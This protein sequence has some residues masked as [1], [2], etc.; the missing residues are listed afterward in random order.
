MR[1]T[2][3][4]VTAA[5]VAAL[6]LTACSGESGD[7]TAKSSTDS[8]SS[9]DSANGKSTAC[10]ADQ[11]GID[12]GPS[13]AAPAAGD[14]GTIPV[15]LTNQGASCTLDGIPDADVY[16][17]DT[18]WAVSPDKAATA[19]KL[20]MAKDQAVTF[21]ITYVRGVAGDAKKAAAVDTVKFTLPGDSAPQS[22]KWPD[23]EVAVKSGDQ[24]DMTVGP[25][26]PAGD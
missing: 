7:D 1:T 25:F 18:S 15:T 23:A 26:L 13:S 8:S 11:F 3:V 20:T 10:K 24:L 9:A 2:P 14:T 4:A 19:T 5:L 6:T 17:G 22:Y 16:A 12:F 21:T